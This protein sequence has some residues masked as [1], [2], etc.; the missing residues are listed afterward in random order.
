[1]CRGSSMPRMPT[2]ADGDEASR[3]GNR[4]D[5]TAT[6]SEPT[7]EGLPAGKAG[8]PAPGLGLSK[9]DQAAGRMRRV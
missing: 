1:M 9:A 6:A 3:G 5:Y 7:R 4:A 8:M 2:P